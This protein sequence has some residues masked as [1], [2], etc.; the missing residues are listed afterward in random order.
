M[1]VL[2]AGAA[3]AVFGAVRSTRKTSAAGAVGGILQVAVVGL[4]SLDPADARDPKAVMVVD[5]L[6]DTLVRNTGDLQPGPGAGPLL[7]R[8]RRADGLH[9]PPRPRRPLRRRQPRHGG[10][11][12]VHPGA[13]RP[14]GLRLA[15][16]RPARSGQRVRRLPHG[17][18]RPR[19]GRHRDAR[20]RHRGGAARPPVLQLPGG[21]RPPGLRDR[22]EGGRGAAGRG[23]Q[24]RPRSGRGRSGGSTPRRRAGSALRR[25]PGR[26][27]RP[28][29]TAST[30]STSRTPT[31]PTPP[32]RTGRSTS[33]PCRPP[34]P[35][36]PPGASGGR[37]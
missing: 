28:G 7:R 3:L 20:R 2:A 27:P 35:P 10:R 31:P 9:L 26:T 6:F 21:A 33:R 16:R 24:G 15:P 12:E 22:A 30:S 25:A 17:R 11:R 36:T 14:Q 23:L 29:S 5:Q 1:V 34:G 37:G 18:H 4:P 19:P 8:Q 13:H 32:S